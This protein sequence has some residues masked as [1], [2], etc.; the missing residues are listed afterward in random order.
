MVGFEIETFEGGVV[1]G[2][3]AGFELEGLGCVGEDW[4]G[5]GGSQEGEG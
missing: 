5:E 4:G 2:E 3:D 1:R